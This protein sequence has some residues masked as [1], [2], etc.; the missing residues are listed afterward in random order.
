MVNKKLAPLTIA[1]IVL[2]LIIYIGKS[3]QSIQQDT[4]TTTETPTTTT[5]TPTPTNIPHTELYDEVVKAAIDALNEYRKREGVPTVEFMP[6]KTPLYRAMYMYNNSYLSHYSRE[7]VH[8]NYFYTILDGGWYSVEENAGYSFCT[9]CINPKEAVVRHIYNMIYNDAESN[10]GHRD[11]L[12]DPCNNKVSVAAAWDSDKLYVVI[13]MVSH[14]AHWISPPSY[15]GTTFSLK[16]Y[17]NLPPRQIS[18]GLA[19]YPILI[20]RDVPNPSYYYRG[21]YSIGDLYA[22]VLPKEYGGYYPNMITIRAD[23]YIVQQVGDT[24]FVDIS[25]RLDLPRDGALYTIVMFSAPTDVAWKP[26]NPVRTKSCR[27]FGYTAK[28]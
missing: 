21:Y 9:K 14:W 5:E 22:G 3:P 8:P 19:L 13:F 17:V 18:Q 10:W 4:F 16:G 1:L 25:F 11:S 15:D 2:A 12:L 6:L 28:T 27:I 20:Y 26:Y 7:G 23:K 24:W